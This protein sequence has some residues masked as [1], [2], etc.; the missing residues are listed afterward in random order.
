M[1][2]V[3]NLLNYQNTDSKLLE[4]E[5]EIATSDEYKNLRQAANFV[6]KANEKLD[7]LDVKARA[8]ASALEE[9]KVKYAEVYETLEEFE[10]LDELIDGG[11]DIS[12]YKKNVLQ[13]SDKLKSI[14][15]E[16]NS[17][18]KSM[19]ATN[20]EFQE[21]YT[22]YRN[23]NK[24]GREY[25]EI[26]AKY[27]AEKD[28]KKEEIKSELEKIAKDIDPEVMK[29]YM[30]KRSERIFPILCPAVQGRCS[31]CGTELSL[32]AKERVLSGGVTECENCHRFIYNEKK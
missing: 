32:S 5:R 2:Q 20:E 25:Q 19:K 11:A 16:I 18:S 22:K 23:V 21:L 7:S 4:I 30:S 17:V 29:R 27:K 6:T 3:E 28:K 26:Y 31:K 14:R 10:N 1:A 13:I 15:Q 24:Q 9:L 12:F 8:L